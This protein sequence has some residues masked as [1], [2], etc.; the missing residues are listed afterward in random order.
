MPL[1]I[2]SYSLWA[3]QQMKPEDTAASLDTTGR[4]LADIKTTTGTLARFFKTASF[5]RQ[6]DAVRTDFQR[7]LTERF[8]ASVA[9]TV[10]QGVGPNLTAAAITRAVSAA[11]LTAARTALTPLGDRCYHLADGNLTISQAAINGMSEEGRTALDR[12]LAASNAAADLLGST[13]A[14]AV[15]LAEARQRTADLTQ[16]LNEAKIA[17]Q[18]ASAEAPQDFQPVELQRL[19]AHCNTM[20]VQLLDHLDHVEDLNA[21]GPLSQGAQDRFRDVWYDSF[22]GA[23]ADLKQHV[24][25]NPAACTA[26]D[27]L[28]STPKAQFEFTLSKEF[29]KDLAKRIETA[30]KEACGKNP[31]PEGAAK[32]AVSQNYQSVLNRRPW[33]PIAK[34]FA[35]AQGGCTFTLTSAITPGKHVAGVGETYPHGINGFMCYSPEEK[36]HAVNLAVSTLSVADGQTPAHTAF[37]GVR[38]GVHCAWEITDPAAR[39]QANRNRATDAVKAAFSAYLSAHP[40]LPPGRAVELPM[41]SVSLLTPECFRPI[42]AKLTGNNSDNE[43]LMLQEQTAAWNALNGRPMQVTVNGQTYTVT[44]KI[45]TFNFGVNQGGVGALSGIIGGWGVSK[46]LNTAAFQILRDRTQAYIDDANIPQDKR[47]AATKIFRQIRSI[48]DKGQERTDNHDAY[49]AAA[50]IAV[51]TSLMDGVPCWNCKSGKDRTGEMDVEC[52]FLATLVDRGLDIPEPGAPLTG[53]QKA[54]FRTIALE[55]GNHEMQEYN[56]GIAGYKT[57]NVDSI[58]ERLGGA[59]ARAFHKGGANYVDV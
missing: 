25:N 38:H 26:L 54:L 10:M 5:T 28:A 20:I 34:T 8:G 51:L 17:L 19:S 45:A 18:M 59:E 29:G 24:V 46:P 57:S 23:C 12:F 43:K 3:S 9:T 1:T 56:T 39:A 55:G 11:Q 16:E 6:R 33:A 42:G 13:P 7:A 22:R 37:I 40:G 15:D 48:L 49:K 32:K 2:D 47:I 30:L 52:K 41:T 31:L 36:D 53:E 14:G 50:R 21:N 44:P 58:P 35:A 4:G 27:T